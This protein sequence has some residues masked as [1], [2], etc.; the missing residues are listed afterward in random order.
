MQ[1]NYYVAAIIRFK[2]PA[3]GTCVRQT[4]KSYIE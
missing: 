1:A 2:I 4:N 3:R